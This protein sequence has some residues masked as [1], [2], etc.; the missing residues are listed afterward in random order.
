MGQTGKGSA[1]SLDLSQLDKS[2]ARGSGGGSGTGTGRALSARARANGSGAGGSGSGGGSGG[3]GTGGAGSGGYQVVW[4]QP[5]ASTGR[6]LLK[7]VQQPKMPPWVSSQGLTLSVTVA[8]T[9]MPD[10]LIGAV[11]VDRSS[12]Y[13]QVDSAVLDAIRHWRFTAAKGTVLVKGV[14]PYVVKPR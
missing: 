8:F 2:L 10:G 4:D 13:P 7:P 9:L 5:E 1:G 14:I 12:G 3:A 11:A 6:E